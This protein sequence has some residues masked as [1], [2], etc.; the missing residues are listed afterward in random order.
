MTTTPIM[1]YTEQSEENL[2]AVNDNKW[3]EEKLM[4]RLEHLDKVLTLDPRWLAVAR[5]H[6]EQGYMALNRAIMQPERLKGD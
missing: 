5:T 6:F 4:R 3:A 1:G 2:A